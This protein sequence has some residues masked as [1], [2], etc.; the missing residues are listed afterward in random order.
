MRVCR[1]K[2]ACRRS[3]LRRDAAIQDRHLA[4]AHARMR[5]RLIMKLT[6]SKGARFARNAG[7]ESLPECLT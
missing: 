4:R 2:L 1:E 5:V 6:A 7:D 3:I